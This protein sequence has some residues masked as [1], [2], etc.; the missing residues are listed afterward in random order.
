[1]EKQAPSL[2]AQYVKERLGKDVIETEFGFAT[3]HVTNTVFYIEDIFV[4]KE[5]RKD[6]H[7]QKLANEAIEWAKRMGFKKVLGSVNLEAKNFEYSM[8][9]MSLF[10]FKPCRAQSNLIFY[11]K[12]I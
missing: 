1:M 12:E 6:G 2:Y 11:E 4:L 5:H 3:I 10:G 7:A 8:K 9:V